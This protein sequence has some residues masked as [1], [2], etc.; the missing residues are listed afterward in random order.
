MSHVNRRGES[1]GGFSRAVGRGHAPADQVG[2]SPRSNRSTAFPLVI[3]MKEPDCRGRRPRR[4]N[5]E[6]AVQYG[7][8]KM[9]CIFRGKSRTLS[10]TGTDFPSSW[11]ACPRPTER[12][13]HI[14]SGYLQKPFDNPGKMC[15]VKR[16]Q[17]SDEDTP[18]RMMPREEPTWCNGSALGTRLDTTSE[19]LTGNGQ[20]GAPVKAPMS[21]GFQP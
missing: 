20:T 8:R 21:D 2:S 1:C 15:Y 18:R 16:V 3:V 17:G 11:W 6:A 19:P 7:I 14:S 13:M 12:N 9:R 4:P 10:P 5:R